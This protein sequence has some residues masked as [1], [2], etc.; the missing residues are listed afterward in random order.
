M[1]GGPGRSSMVP[2]SRM[3]HS[4]S[5]DHNLGYGSA[6]AVS[7][8]RTAAAIGTLMFLLVFSVTIVQLGLGDG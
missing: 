2:G 6:I 4:I 8:M 3:Y 7:I 5:R 1:D